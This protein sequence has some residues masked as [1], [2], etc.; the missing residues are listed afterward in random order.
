MIRYIY[1]I[2]LTLFFFILWGC[3][4]EVLD[5]NNVKFNYEKIKFKRNIGNK[6]EEYYDQKV[7]ERKNFK[8]NLSFHSMR[9]LDEN[10]QVIFFQFKTEIKP[11]NC[12][13]I[14]DCFRNDNIEIIKKYINKL[15]KLADK[16]KNDRKKQIYKMYI[17]NNFIRKLLLYAYPNYNFTS[18]EIYY[19]FLNYLLN[20]KRECLYYKKIYNN[21]WKKLKLNK[22]L[23]DNLKGSQFDR[24]KFY[25][26]FFA[27]LV[28]ILKEKKCGYNI[29][30]DQFNTDVL[31]I[32]D[33]FRKNFVTF[34]DYKEDLKKYFNCN[35]ISCII[36]N[37]YVKFLDTI[38][39]LDY[40]NL[41][42]FNRIVL[43]KD[44]ILYTSIPKDLSTNINDLVIDWYLI[45]SLFKD[46]MKSPI[47]KIWMK[48]LFNIYINKN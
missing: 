7:I 29:Y 44:E 12:Y 15:I 6:K 24:I 42:Y 25:R 28:S 8:N 4:K 34:E 21:I 13:N 3:K 43:P 39:K 14:D 46:I 20:W 33:D 35:T 41:S 18:E 48:N 32:F 23:I 30:D 9:F 19:R 11:L 38:L 36:N 22:S 1:Y 26:K 17:S 5:S 16:V 31:A 27:I 2:L 40:F 45:N 47:N 10:F 37:F